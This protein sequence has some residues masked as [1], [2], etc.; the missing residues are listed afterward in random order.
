MLKNALPKIITNTL[1]GP[2]AAE[3]MNRR[4][5]AVP[6]G[7]RCTY[8]CVMK[9]AAG[10]MIEDVD[11]NLFLDW[12]G[13]VG[14]LNVG[15]CHPKLVAA[16]KAQSENFFHGMINIVTHEGYVE[17]AEKLAATAPTRGTSNK[18]MFAN[19]GAEAD[20]N[21]VKIAKAYTSRPNILIYIA[22]LVICRKQKQ[23]NIILTLF[24]KPLRKLPLLNMWLL[25]LWNL[26]KEKVDSFL[27]PLN[28]LKRFVKYV[29][30]MV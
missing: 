17:L 29:T 2:K 11:G 27:P 28:G 6:N 10:A 20:E 15:H 12:I 1:P 18:V 23:L 24:I 5:D 13:G 19:S 30:I 14:V 9:Q 22:H 21:A 7:I 4:K 16:V 25:L 8:P 3:I 26:Y